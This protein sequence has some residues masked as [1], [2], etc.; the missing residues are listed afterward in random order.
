MRPSKLAYGEY[1]ANYIGLVK[2]DDVHNA[3]ANSVTPS[4]EFWNSLTEEQGNYRYAEGKWS[5]KELL[6]L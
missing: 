3:L 6:Q 2:E 5:I 4:T 1:Y